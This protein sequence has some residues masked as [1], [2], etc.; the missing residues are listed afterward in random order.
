MT[1]A[2]PAEEMNRVLLLPARS[3]WCVPWTTLIALRF[4]RLRRAFAY[5]SATTRPEDVAPLREIVSGIAGLMDVSDREEAWQGL[6]VRGIRRRA[7]M[8][9]S[10]HRWLVVAS[11]VLALPALALLG[12]GGFPVAAGVQTYLGEDRWPVILSALGCADL[13]LIGVRL[14]FLVRQSV[15]TRDHPVGELRALVR[16]RLWTATGA[17]VA[18]VALLSQAVGG[19]GPDAPF[20]SNFHLLQALSDFEVWLGFALLL[21]ALLALFPPGGLLSV[22]AGGAAAAVGVAAPSLVAA[23]ALGGA[24]PC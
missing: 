8:G 23:A 14:V 2:E 9:T 20:I 5:A 13:V 7:R 12:I 1:E 10:S 22:G 18:G 4:A 3:A 11:W 24:A 19:T 16:F 6:D 15:G 21:L 17:A